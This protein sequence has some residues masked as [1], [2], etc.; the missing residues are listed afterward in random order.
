MTATTGL[1]A[2]S[3]LQEITFSFFQIKFSSKGC[4][5]DPCRKRVGRDKRYNLLYFLKIVS[6]LQSF[7]FDL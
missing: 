4:R 6:Q 3:L 7:N 2:V 1:S 5:Y